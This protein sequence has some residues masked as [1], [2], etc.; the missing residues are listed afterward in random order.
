MLV[1]TKETHMYNVYTVTYVHIYTMI[2]IEDKNNFIFFTLNFCNIEAKY[3][4]S[5][6]FLIINHFE[7]IVEFCKKIYLNK[8]SSG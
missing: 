8:I 2:H 1:N 7:I 4:S 3:S 6:F 5:Y